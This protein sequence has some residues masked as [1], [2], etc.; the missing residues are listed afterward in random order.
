[1]AK[2]KFSYPQG[3]ILCRA[4]ICGKGKPVL[5]KMAIDTGSTK[6]II[7]PEAA[8]SIG[9][10]PAHSK[11]TTEIT[12]GSGTVMCPVVTIP[13]FS[14]LGI[15]CKKLDV[16]CHNLPPESPVEGLLGLDFFKGHLVII[17][18]H[19]GTLEVR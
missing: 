16:V 1:M 7:P 10:N 6:T 18:F 8:L 15:T 9:I 4:K 17:D 19:K 14:C 3:L 11:R 5:L 13:K 12:T 2:I